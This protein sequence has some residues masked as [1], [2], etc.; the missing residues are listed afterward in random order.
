MDSIN[1]RFLTYRRARSPSS[2][3]FAL[4]PHLSLSLF[5]ERINQIDFRISIRARIRIAVII[6]N[7]NRTQ[8]KSDRLLSR[9]QLSREIKL[10]VSSEIINSHEI[11][12]TRNRHLF[13][14]PNKSARQL[15]SITAAV[16]LSN[17]CDRVAVVETTKFRLKETKNSKTTPWTRSCVRALLRFRW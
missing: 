4:S 12:F 5:R 10:N 16:A 1:Y 3:S 13:M 6:R 7:D 14:E 9:V 15:T 17:R 2:P 8:T 11:H